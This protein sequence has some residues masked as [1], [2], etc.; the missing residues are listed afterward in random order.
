M[1]DLPTMDVEEVPVMAVEEVPA[2]GLPVTVD[3]E[4]PT[5]QE[6]S[7]AAIPTI[8]VGKINIHWNLL[9]IHSSK[10]GVAP[11]PVLIPTFNTPLSEE[12]KAEIIQRERQKMDEEASVTETAVTDPSGEGVAVAV[13]DP[14]GELVE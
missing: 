12:K 1:S 11:K 13:T 8:L 5:L 9:I 3:E 14:S 10:K 4:V 2:A 6:A 7:G